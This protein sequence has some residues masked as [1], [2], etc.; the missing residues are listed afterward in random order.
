[1]AFGPT[2][3]R[4]IKQSHLKNWSETEIRLRACRLLKVY[5][6][7][8][9]Y[10]QEFRFANKEAIMEARKENSKVENFPNGARKKYGI[11]FHKDAMQ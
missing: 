4:S 2:D 9:L 6:L 8:K 3:Y 1:M 11:T 7:D 10:P 5:Q